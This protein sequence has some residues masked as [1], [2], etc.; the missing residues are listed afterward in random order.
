MLLCNDINGIVNKNSLKNPLH[1]YKG[2]KNTNIN[3][4]EFNFSVKQL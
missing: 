1:G 3:P 2:R 4:S